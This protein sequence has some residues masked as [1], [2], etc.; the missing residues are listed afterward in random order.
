VS[1][2]QPTNAVKMRTE[3]GM[4]Y[5]TIVHE[6]VAVRT[7]LKGQKIRIVKNSRE[8]HSLRWL[9]T[10]GVPEGEATWVYITTG[11][12]DKLLDAFNKLTEPYGGE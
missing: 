2:K 6:G 1:K 12:L 9:K 4:G 11:T 8:I 7:W 5:F 10:K 3:F